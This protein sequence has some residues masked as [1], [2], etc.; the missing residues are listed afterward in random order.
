MNKDTIIIYHGD[1]SDGFGGA[2]SAWK[3]FG[4]SADYFGA[5]HGDEPPQELKDKVIYFIDFVYPR[6]IMEVLKKA[7]KKIIII[8]HHKT[9][10]DTIELADEKLF[11]MENSGA[12]LSWQYFHPDKEIPT[13]IRHIEDR[14]LWNW[15]MSG[16]REVLASFDLLSQDFQSWDSAILDF[17]NSDEKRKGFVA[18]GGLLMLQWNNLCEDI[19]KD[20]A[21]L[22]EFEGIRTYSVNASSVFASDL[23]NMLS[24]KLS[25]IAIVWHQK[26]DG[27]FVVSLRS[28]GTCDVS[29]IAKKY[30]GGGHSAAAGFRIL[31]DNPFP[32]KIIKKDV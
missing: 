4:E 10:S 15:N 21:V 30:G 11:D 19:I 23:G 3:K 16:T 1:C 17:D 18:N 2:W 31:A 8:D 5:H 9:A 13:I 29:E 27:N 12:V 14:D 32:W 26:E 28:D 24:K 7:N 22:V 25:P 6:P 20:D